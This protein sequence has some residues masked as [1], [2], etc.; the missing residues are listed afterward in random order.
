LEYLARGIRQVEET[1][2]IQIEKEEVKL[3]L[4]TDDM[5]FYLKEWKNIKNS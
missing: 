4:F 5:I 2:G 1:K 3:S